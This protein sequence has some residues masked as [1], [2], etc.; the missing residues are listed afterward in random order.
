MKA[1]SMELWVKNT[2]L[3]LMFFFLSN[4]YKKSLLL[5]CFISCFYPINHDQEN[6]K[7]LFLQNVYLFLSITCSRR[8]HNENECDQ[9]YTQE[10]EK[11]VLN[12]VVVVAVFIW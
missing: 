6:K 4:I 10:P 7:K 9:K 1:K 3:D 11:S 8:Q 2:L 12:V 5:L